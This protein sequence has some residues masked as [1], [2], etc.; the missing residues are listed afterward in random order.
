MSAERR[1]AIKM[2]F[3]TEPPVASESDANSDAEYEDL[4]CEPAV[5]RHR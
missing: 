4:D 5:P 2:R 3:V 1:S